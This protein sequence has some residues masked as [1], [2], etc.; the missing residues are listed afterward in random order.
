MIK[1]KSRL[2]ELLAEKHVTP[3]DLAVSSGLP[4]E[5]IEQYC[6]EPIDTISLREVEKIMSALGC[7]EI[8]DLLEEVLVEATPET[9]EEYPEPESE[10]NTR[11]PTA[12]DGK[13]RWY[14]D[15]DASDPLYQEYVCFECGERM[16]V[17]L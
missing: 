13:H 5:T 10:W 3:Q 17:I 4:M 16:S 11:C 6:S 14:K 2:T 9:D 7:T 1:I 15:M 12:P 8:T